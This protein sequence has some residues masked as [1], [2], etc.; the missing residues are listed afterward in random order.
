MVKNYLQFKTSM[1]E[2]ICAFHIRPQIEVLWGRAFAL[3]FPPHCRAFASMSAPVP[4]VF[5]IHKN[6]NSWGLA[7]GRGEV[8]AQLK[9][10]DA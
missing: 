9:L 8:W 2:N 6:E 7:R 3:F 10:T 5:A 1:L 4:G